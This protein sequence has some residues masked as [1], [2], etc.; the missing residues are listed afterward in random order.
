MIRNVL[1]AFMICSGMT[2]LGGCSSVMSHT[3]GKEGTYPGT[4]ASATMIGDDE[5][6]WGTKSLAILDMPF[7]AVLD[8]ILLP[9]DVFRKDSSVRSR[10]EKSEANA[11]A[12]NAVIPPARMPDN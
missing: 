9:W 3:G 6:N 4:R 10:V 1:L 7:T 8:T 2:L 5:T 11:Q 12:T